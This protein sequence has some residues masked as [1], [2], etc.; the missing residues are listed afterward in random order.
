MNQAWAGSP[1]GVYAAAQATVTLLH[2]T[3]DWD[4]DKN[5]SLPLWQAYAKP[6]PDGAVAV[7]VVNHGAAAAPALI[8]FAA[9]PGLACTDCTVTD[10]WQQQALGS[11]SQ[12]FSVPALASHDSL[13]VVLR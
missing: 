2:C 12:N 10:V 3:P 6:L 11:F 4:G 7:L 5:C 13:F 9:V 1:G 8:S